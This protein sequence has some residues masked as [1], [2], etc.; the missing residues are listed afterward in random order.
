MHDYA[1]VSVQY[2][3]VGFCLSIWEKCKYR[4]QSDV[5]F[6]FAVFGVYSRRGI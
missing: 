3:A 2:M 6:V 1:R 4:L 5:H